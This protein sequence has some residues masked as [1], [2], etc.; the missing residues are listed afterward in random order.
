MI[1]TGKNSPYFKD[2][3]GKT[4]IAK[5]GM[6]MTIVKY[7][8]W[9]DVDVLFEDG[10]LVSHVSYKDFTLGCIRH[11]DPMKQAR[12][13]AV[14]KHIGETNTAKNGMQ[15]TV[16]VY[17][18][19]IDIDIQ[20][21]DGAIVQ[22][23]TYR[24]FQDGKIRHPDPEK[25][26][27][28]KA[29]VAVG[30]THKANND[31]IM[32]IIAVHGYNDIDVQ[33][34][35]GEIVKNRTYSAFLH[36][37]IQHPSKERAILYKCKQKNIGKTNTNTQGLKMTV[38]AYYGS[39]DVTIQFEDGTVVEHKAMQSFNRGWVR[40]P[41]YVPQ[42]RVGET[43]RNHQGYMMRIIKYVSSHNVTV[44]FED[45]TIL[46][47]CAYAGFR[48]GHLMNPNHNPHLNETM[49]NAQGLT[50]RIIRYAGQ[51]DVDIEYETGCCI[52]HKNYDYFVQG[53]YNH[54]FP[55][56]IGDITMNGFAYL[57]NTVGNFY[58]TCESCGMK[59]ILSIAEV[60]NHVCQNT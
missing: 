57:H 25:R 33:F 12:K 52:T 3:T 16:I 35:D 48:D 59:D 2:R 18:K 36:G 30:E 54:P 31:M 11:P 6:K 53:M 43:N 23:Q 15:M 32:T 17:R 8:M 29:N 56:K 14:P 38:I 26:A 7:R 5:N 13:K 39:T 9:N 42:S 34:E 41:N 49:V 55:H 28:R 27:K 58:C 46:E 40:N 45:G 24:A 1:K 19:A 20:F 10:A 51:R 50:M 47:H 60:R 44:K 4:T 21:E 22:H 37:S